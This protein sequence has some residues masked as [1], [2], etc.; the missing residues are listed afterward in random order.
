MLIDGFTKRMERRRA[1]HLWRLV[2]GT[3]F[4]RFHGEESAVAYQ[5]VAWMEASDKIHQTFSEETFQTVQTRHATF[6]EVVWFAHCS[7][8]PWSWY[9]R[10]AREKCQ[11]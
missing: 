7:A 11:E 3:F 8:L 4:Q 9:V 10:T 5:R 1:L 2:G 6:S